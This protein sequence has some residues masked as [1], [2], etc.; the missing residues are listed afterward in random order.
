MND[1]GNVLPQKTFIS[2]NVGE[3]NSDTEERKRKHFD[4]KV[5]LKLGDS[6]SLPKDPIEDQETYTDDTKE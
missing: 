1:N 2:L 4:A 3:I 6:L 5:K